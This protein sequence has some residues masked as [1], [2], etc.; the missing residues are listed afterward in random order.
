MPICKKTIQHRKINNLCPRCG[1]PNANGKSLCQKH[2]DEF[3]AKTLKY[4]HKRLDKGLCPQCNGSIREGQYYCDIC[5][6]KNKPKQQRHYKK[7]YKYIKENSLCFRC[8]KETINNKISCEECSLKINK[9][10]KKQYE[11]LL[12]NN[13]CVLC[14]KNKVIDK[15]YCGECVQKRNIWYKKSDTRIKNKIEREKNKKIVLDH[16]GNKCVICRETDTDVLSIDHINNDGKE[17]RKQTGI[18]S[19]FYDWIIENNFPMDL[20]ILCCNCNIK[21][22]K[23][24]LNLRNY[25]PDK[26]KL[27]EEVSIMDN[28]KIDETKVYGVN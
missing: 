10:N 8:G 15:T 28:R 9:I 17:H 7:R 26:Q 16:Y 2:L 24:T 12:K 21:K 20:Q 22:Y 4:R 25:I 6:E 23:Q 3:A 27:T 11:Q 14:G 19:H 18:G 13:L 1:Q 5:I